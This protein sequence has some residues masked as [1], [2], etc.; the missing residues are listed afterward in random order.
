MGGNRLGGVNW[1]MESNQGGK[2]GNCDRLG[3]KKGLQMK[4]SDEKGR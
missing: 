2:G 1:Q 4:E 3:G